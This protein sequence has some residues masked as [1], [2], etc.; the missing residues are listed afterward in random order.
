MNIYKQSIAP[1]FLKQFLE[2]V[3][4]ASSEVLVCEQWHNGPYFSLEQLQNWLFVQMPEMPIEQ[5]M[6]TWQKL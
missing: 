2:N 1:I 6:F 5:P 3:L 4:D